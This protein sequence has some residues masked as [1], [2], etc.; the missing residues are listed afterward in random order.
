[1]EPFRDDEVKVL[2]QMIQDYQYNRRH[3]AARVR[4]VSRAQLIL[5]SVLGVAMVT[6]NF[7]A[8]VTHR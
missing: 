5:A 6:L 7:L 4:L 2:R 1:M 8:L 3:D